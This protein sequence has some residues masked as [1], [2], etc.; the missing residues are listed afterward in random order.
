[1]MSLVRGPAFG[2]AA[3]LVAAFVFGLI[4]W[5][6]GALSPGVGDVLRDGSSLGSPS[7]LT[8]WRGERRYGLVLG[9]LTGILGFLVGVLPGWF[10]VSERDHYARGDSPVFALLLGLGIGVAVG[11]GVLL[12]SSRTWAS[13]FA[14]LQMA[15]H[16]HTPV[17]LMR[18]LEDA[19]ER[20]VMRTVG[21]VYQFRHARL[22]DR[23]AKQES[24]SA[25][26]EELSRASGV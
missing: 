3:G 5:L 16:R 13:S 22:Q 20:G 7:P 1:M 26:T 19:R 17:R 11:L 4:G 9:L 25:P 10:V 2:L 14:C 23:L 15:R 18:F 12:A 21:P 24:T 8:S 6:I